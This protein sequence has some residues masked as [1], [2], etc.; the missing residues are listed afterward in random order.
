[1]IKLGAVLLTA[2]RPLTFKN[3]VISELYKEFLQVNGV[4]DD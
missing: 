2:E 3:A 4:S 1:M